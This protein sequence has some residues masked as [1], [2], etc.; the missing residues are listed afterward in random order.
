MLSNIIIIHGIEIIM[1]KHTYYFLI[2]GLFSL[3]LI[4]NFGY[5][6][7]ETTQTLFINNTINK[8]N[9]L[10]PFYIATSLECL[11]SKEIKSSSLYSF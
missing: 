2:I 7:G 3:N 6:N 9:E 5:G 4:I 1:Q 10:E 11:N 8:I